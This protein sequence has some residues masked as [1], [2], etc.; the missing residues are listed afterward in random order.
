MKNIFKNK[1]VNSHKL[2][3]FGFVDN[4]YS[5]DILDGSFNLTVKIAENNEVQTELIEKDTGELYTLHLVEYVQGSFVGKVKEEYENILTEIAENCFEQDVF[6]SKQSKLIIEYVKDKYGDEL[7]YL[8][9]KFP[10]NAVCRRKDNKKWYLAI[11]TVAKNKLGFES[12]KKVE[13]IDLRATTE[14]IEKIVDNKKYFA[15]YHMNKKHWLTIILDGSVL[16]KEI[17]DRINISYNI[18]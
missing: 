13:I 5:T 15:G 11:L 17:Y 12:D 6:K 10:D 14:E 8:W 3:E 16:I 18:D 1:K 7:E 9:E 4:K 2:A